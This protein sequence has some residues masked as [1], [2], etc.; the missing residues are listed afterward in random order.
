VDQVVTAE[1]TK[2]DPEQ[3]AWALLNSL[4]PHHSW[5]RDP[6]LKDT[7]TR[8][9]KMLRDLTTPIDINWKDFP[10]SVDEMVVVQDIPFNSLCAHHLVPYIGVA[11]IAYLPTKRICGLSKIVRVVKHFAASLSV[12]EELTQQI[13]NYLHNALDPVGV[14][15]VVEAEHLCMALRGVQAPGVKTTTSCMK[16]AFADHSRQARSEFLNLIRGK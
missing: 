2:V 10:S 4:W 6:H 7:P 14:A 8:F 15:V 5:N 13:A 16:G 3:I 1:M 11:H 12:Q 9:V